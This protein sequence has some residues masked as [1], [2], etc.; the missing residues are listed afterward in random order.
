MQIYTKNH[1]LIY[2][3]EGTVLSGLILLGGDHV[4]T[5]C[6]LLIELDKFLAVGGASQFMMRAC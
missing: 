3:I 1:L 2:P 4:Q 6:F 5:R